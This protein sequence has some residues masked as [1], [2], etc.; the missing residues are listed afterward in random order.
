MPL[1][2]YPNSDIDPE[3]INSEDRRLQFEEI[4]TRANADIDRDKIRKIKFIRLKADQDRGTL[5]Y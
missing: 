3:D 5:A 1:S 4:R 2:R